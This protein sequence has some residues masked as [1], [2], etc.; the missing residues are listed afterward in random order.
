MK[1]TVVS[2]FVPHGSI[3]LRARS[4]TKIN[5]LSCLLLD[6]TIW[7]SCVRNYGCIRTRYGV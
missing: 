3:L 4:E 1:Y 5:E 6:D 2:Y 7:S